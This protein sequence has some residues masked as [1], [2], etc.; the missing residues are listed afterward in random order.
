MRSPPADR[1]PI[2]HRRLEHFPAAY[3][4]KSRGRGSSG[5]PRPTCDG[6]SRAYPAGGQ[7]AWWDRRQP[8]M[9]LG[10]R[11][12]TEYPWVTG[13]AVADCEGTG[14]PR[15][16][17]WTWFPRCSRQKLPWPG[18]WRSHGW[19]LDCAPPQ[20]VTPARRS[21]RGYQADHLA[22]VEP[23][24]RTSG[25]MAG[26]RR[27]AGGGESGWPSPTERERRGGGDAPWCARRGPRRRWWQSP[28]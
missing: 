28:Q 20:G 6:R 14:Q 16:P 7:V 9:R 10:T 24:S 5:R 21:G 13:S 19:I 8:A 15:T 27:D 11:A 2:T 4:A 25:L 23:T 12:G 18:H 26:Y 17:Q 3:F 22:A 1:C